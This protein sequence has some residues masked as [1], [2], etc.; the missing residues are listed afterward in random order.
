MLAGASKIPNF[1]EFHYKLGFSLLLV[2]VI[3]IVINIAQ[4]E[5]NLSAVKM[6]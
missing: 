3:I 1:D 6:I 5:F 2:H 4:Y